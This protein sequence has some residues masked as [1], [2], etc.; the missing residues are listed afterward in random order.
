[1]IEKVGVHRAEVIG[2]TE[3]SSIL[4]GGGNA[5][6]GQLAAIGEADIKT[7]LT[8]ADER[9]RGSH[10]RLH[11][12]SVPE[13]ANFNVGGSPAPHPGWWQL[14]TE[15]RI[16]CRCF[17]FHGEFDKREM[18]EII[19]GLEPEL[20]ETIGASHSSGEPLA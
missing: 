15:H 19:G 18:D 4:N 17:L 1:M 2:E 12:V 14:P 20:K 11:M 3:T 5:A 10:R 9:V 7:W 13:D 16:A 8:M 6:G